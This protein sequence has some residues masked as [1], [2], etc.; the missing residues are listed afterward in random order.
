MTPN[1]HYNKYFRFLPGLEV[2]QQK[3]TKK[4]YTKKQQKNAWKTQTNKRKKTISTED[5]HVHL[6][7]IRRV[8][9]RSTYKLNVT[10]SRA[11]YS[12][13]FF[14]SSCSSSTCCVKRTIMSSFTVKLSPSDAR[15]SLSA[16]KTGIETSPWLVSSTSGCDS[17][18]SSSNWKRD[19]TLV[20]PMSVSSS[21]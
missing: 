18:L 13:K 21:V 7:H 6:N 11:V 5:C 20:R 17:S 9:K 2:I 15:L 16:G 8:N 12:F 14:T 3:K 19:L 4:K 1:M 10:C